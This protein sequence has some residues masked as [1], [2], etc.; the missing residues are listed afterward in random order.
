VGEF[1]FVA[2]EIVRLT[3]LRIKSEDGIKK[4]MAEI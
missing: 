2:E 4:H 1:V 3:R